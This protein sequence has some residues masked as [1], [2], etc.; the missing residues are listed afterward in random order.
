MPDVHSIHHTS[1]EA[2]LEPLVH[3]IKV[4]RPT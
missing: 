2:Y 1:V 3:E 4:R